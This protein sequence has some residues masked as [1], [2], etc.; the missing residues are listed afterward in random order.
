MAKPAGLPTAQV[1]DAREKAQDEGDTETAKR[2]CRRLF[3][4]AASEHEG[5]RLL[6]SLRSQVFAPALAGGDFGSLIREWATPKNLLTD[7]FLEEAFFLYRYSINPHSKELSSVITFE[8]SMP[9]Y[10]GSFRLPPWVTKEDAEKYK[11]RVTTMFK[12]FLSDSMD[13]RKRLRALARKREGSLSYRWAAEYICLNKPYEKI[14]DP[15]GCDWRSIQEQ[16]KPIIDFIG[17]RKARIRPKRPS[18]TGETS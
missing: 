16:V 18:I 17:L 5:I 15:R 12:S 9:V 3:L 14:E 6:E 13:R 8:S 2:E 11:K 4:I 7:W 1:R 10:E